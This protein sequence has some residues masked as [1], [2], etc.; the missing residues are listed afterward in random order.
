MALGGSG[1][2]AA[3]RVARDIMREVLIRN[4]SRPQAKVPPK[5]GSEPVREG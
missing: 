2:G 4:P 3:A 1:W 5:G